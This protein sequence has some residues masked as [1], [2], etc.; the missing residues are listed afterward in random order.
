MLANSTCMAGKFSQEIE[1]KGHLVD[2]LILSKIFNIVIDVGGEF[3]V[4]EMDIGK[5]KHDES[6]A[7][8]QVLGKNKAQLDKI[9]ELTYREG[10]TSKHQTSV[11]L[12]PAPSN[13]VMPKGFYSTTN[14]YTKIYLKKK[15]IKVQNTMMDKCIVVK[16]STATCVAIRDV[17]HGDLVVVGE[18]GNKRSV[19]S[20]TS[21]RRRQHI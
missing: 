6:Y 17:Q 14:N 15:W 11:K 5:K 20:K 19:T 9:L 16:K 7:R 21:H 18:D 1:V 3:E 13:M 12:K 2:S 10:A 4:L 8:L